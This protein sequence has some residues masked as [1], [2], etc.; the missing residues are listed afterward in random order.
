VTF[1]PR[2]RTDHRAKWWKDDA[3]C[4]DQDPLIYDTD[5]DPFPHPDVRCAL[6]TV[7]PAC[8]TYALN[9]Q[10]SGTWGGLSRKQRERIQA[11]I[12]HKRKLRA[13]PVCGNTTLSHQDD[14]GMG[15][16]PS[17]GFTWRYVKTAYGDRAVTAM[18]AASQPDPVNPSEV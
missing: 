6:C 17:C 4:R 1:A 14:P 8:L 11:R 9:G 7:R 2:L 18:R 12:S 10:E 13:C 5:D 16:C 3:A 15:N